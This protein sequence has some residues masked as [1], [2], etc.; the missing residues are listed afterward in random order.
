MDL[1]FQITV[2]AD[3]D[4]KLRKTIALGGATLCSNTFFCARNPVIAKEKTIQQADLEIKRQTLHILSYLLW[5]KRPCK[6]AG[7]GQISLLTIF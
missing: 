3:G 4:Q 2:G 6:K 5:L 1:I 7:Y